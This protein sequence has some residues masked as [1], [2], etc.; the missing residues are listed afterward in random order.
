[1]RDALIQIVLRL[2]D[3]VLRDRETG[4]RNQPPA[5]SDNN[6]FFSPGNTSSGFALPPSFM[7]SV[8]QVAPVDFDRRPETGNSMSMLSSG[9]GT[10]GYGSFQ[11]TSHSSTVLLKPNDLLPMFI[12]A[13]TH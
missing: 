7:P 6:S 3:D 2:R 8:P 11:V 12:V 1:M 10:Y 13:N 4:Y 9:S 5:R